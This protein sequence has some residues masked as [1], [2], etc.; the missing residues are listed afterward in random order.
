MKNKKI[1]YFGTSDFAA[2]ILDNIKN[3][4]DIVMV[5][6]RTDK[7]GKR[8]NKLIQNAVKKTAI[9]LKIPLLDTEDLNEI[10]NKLNNYLFDFSIV[11][12]YGKFLPQNIIDLPKEKTLN[13][14]ASILP[15]YRG[16]SPI[17]TTLLNGDNFTGNTIIEITSKMDAG[18]IYST[19]I[20]K[21][22]D[23]DNTQTLSKKLASDGSDLLI[24]TL[25]NFSNIIPVGQDETL[26]TYTKIISK[27]DGYI[28]WKTE[29]S[30]SI[31]NK[32]RALN[33]NPGCYSFLNEI[34][35]NFYEAK[36]VDFQ[37]APGV[38]SSQKDKLYIGTI[39]NALEVLYL[40]ISGKK[41]ISGPDF[42]NGFHHF[43]GKILN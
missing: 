10:Y 12:S 15:K 36:F 23:S 19:S 17:Q 8:G 25:N 7:K 28:N 16:P 29:K 21:I 5:I 42:I 32:I 4:F 18:P 1:V 31:L 39:D 35:L 38:I 24:K 2:I 3:Y 20:V 22:E 34:K 11:A 27:Q 43:I 33:Y 6:T 41:I 14:H 9:D 30:I 40:K 13:I 37:I 26:A